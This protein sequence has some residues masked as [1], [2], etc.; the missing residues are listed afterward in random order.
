MKKFKENTLEIIATIIYFSIPIFVMY[1][2]VKIFF[3]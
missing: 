3:G 1:G 2:I